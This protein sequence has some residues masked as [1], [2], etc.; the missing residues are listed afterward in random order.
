MKVLIIGKNSYIGKHIGQYILNQGDQ[1]AYISV[2]DNRWKQEDFSTFDAVVFAAAIV[3]CKGLADAALYDQVNTQLPRE[4][5]EKVQAQG[6]RKF[7]FLSTAAVYGAEK[8]LPKGCV[9]SKDTPLEPKDLYGKSKLKAER[10]LMELA[11]EKFSV[12]VIR[13]MNVYGKNCPGNYIA[14]FQKLTCKL[15]FLPKAFTEVKQGMVHVEHLAK[16]CYLVLQTNSSGIYHAQDPEPVS[17]YEMMAAMAK[18]M[19]KKKKEVPCHVL[20]RCFSRLR[21]VVKLFGGVAYDQE[22]VDCSLGSYCDKST[23]EKLY[24]VTEK[25]GD[26]S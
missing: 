7:L 20:V 9:I 2:R 5:G 15:P 3:H 21:L 22:L 12:S 25:L 17:S 11:S 8:N 4:F 18:G 24:E 1:V 10:L 6:V 26:C 19:N 23:S 14:S 13:P 16:L